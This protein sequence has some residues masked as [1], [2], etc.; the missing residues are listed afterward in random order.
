MS[1]RP[2]RRADEPPACLYIGRE[3]SAC[4]TSWPKRNGGIVLSKWT[5]TDHSGRSALP[6]RNGNA[7]HAGLIC[8]PRGSLRNSSRRAAAPSKRRTIDPC[9]CMM[10][11][12]GVQCRLAWPDRK[13]PA[14]AACSIVGVAQQS[15]TS[16]R[17][18]W[19]GPRPQNRS[20]TPLGRDARGI[21]AEP[22][23]R[24]D[25]RPDASPRP[26][27]LLGGF[28]LVTRLFVNRGKLV[29]RCSR[30]SSGRRK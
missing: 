18:G 5:R 14:A 25:A 10:T 13:T 20:V 4:S 27:Q 11:D 17:R 1:S 12:T 16:L 6:S 8:A 29:R 21:F 24:R 9:A 19:S 7:L 28:E 30:H 26:R 3:A 15:E 22:P 2:A 23:D